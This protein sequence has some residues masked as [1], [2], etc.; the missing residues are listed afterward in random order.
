MHHSQRNRVV[1]LSF[2]INK[3]K[4]LK[5]V[6]P[7]SEMVLKHYICIFSKWVFKSDPMLMTG[8]AVLVFGF[9]LFEFHCLPDFCF[10][11]CWIRRKK[12]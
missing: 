3:K 10:L 5:I 12:K 1:F 4:F 6:E 8:C 7:E 11:F 9:R 2:R